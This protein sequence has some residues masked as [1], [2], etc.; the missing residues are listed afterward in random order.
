MK[1]LYFIYCPQ[2]KEYIFALPCLELPTQKYDTDGSMKIPIYAYIELMHTSKDFIVLLH[3]DTVDAY[4]KLPLEVSNAF[5]QGCTHSEFM[6]SANDKM[7]VIYT[8]PIS[9]PS[10]VMK[11]MTTQQDIDAQSFRRFISNVFKHKKYKK[12]IEILKK[13]A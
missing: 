12:L 3:K 7:V 10:L 8:T 5:V 13:S 4:I 6:D 11:V 1:K 2:T 9:M